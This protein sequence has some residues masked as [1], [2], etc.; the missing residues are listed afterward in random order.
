MNDD[1]RSSRALVLTR[2]SVIPSL[3]HVSA[4][5]KTSGKESMDRLSL[6]HA[7][8][9][10]R[11][12]DS[13]GFR[14]YST[15]MRHSVGSYSKLAHTVPRAS[16]RPPAYSPTDRRYAVQLTRRSTSPPASLRYTAYSPTDRRYAIQLSHR[17]PSPEQLLSVV[18]P[19]TP[20][21]TGTGSTTRKR[22]LN[23]YWSWTSSVRRDDLGHR[24]KSNT[25][26]GQPRAFPFNRVTLRSPAGACLFLWIRDQRHS[27]RPCP[28]SD[29]LT[30]NSHAPGCNGRAGNVE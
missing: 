7:G 27:C 28:H 6:A 23:T 3:R 24:R 30:C 22:I 12:S 8:Y 26:S 21:P 10:L 5:G 13:V 4:A 2:H 9:G 20:H 15:A 19:L 14:K 25:A 17:P 29:Q 16:L 11:G 18:S 1:A